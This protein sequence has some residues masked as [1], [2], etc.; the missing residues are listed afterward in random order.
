MREVLNPEE[1]RPI[2]ISSMLYHRK[3]NEGELVTLGFRSMIPFV[4]LPMI[5]FFIPI[6]LLVNA[7]PLVAIVLVIAYTPVYVAVARYG[8][9][10]V[11]S[12]GRIAML[13]ADAET[14]ALLGKD[15]LLD[16][17]RRIDRFRLDHVE[18]LKGRKGKK[19]ERP[20][21]TKRIQNLESRFPSSQT[22][23]GY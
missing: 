6:I 1:W 4:F 9:G 8:F 18:K 20:S 22:R 7:S 11:S 17:L 3:M 10:R 2:I 13:E 5:P 15:S 16:V 23:D 12:I 14:D 19:L 21:I